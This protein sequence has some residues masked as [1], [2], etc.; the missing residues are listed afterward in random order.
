[1]KGHQNKCQ[2]K[3]SQ[4]PETVIEAAKPTITLP[5][6][7]C[8]ST[9][10]SAKKLTSHLVESHGIKP[11]ACIY[12][13][14]EFFS[15]V[16]MK[17]HQ[18]YCPE[19]AKQEHETIRKRRKHSDEHS[20]QTKRQQVDLNCSDLPTFFFYDQIVDANPNQTLPKEKLFE[21]DRCLSSYSTE[22]LLDSHKMIAHK[23]FM[24][25]INRYKGTWL[26]TDELPKAAT[27]K[28]VEF[29]FDESPVSYQRKTPAKKSTQIEADP[30]LFD[31]VQR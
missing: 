27:P 6:E 23:P 9:F 25:R 19:K 1:M 2:G 29:N 26:Q 8:T 20:T 11:F 22:L 30:T 18:L 4:E 15:N 13:G 16:G 31:S 3:A 28:G 7:H 21:C 24:P 17:R 10:P 12:C 5:C 14:L